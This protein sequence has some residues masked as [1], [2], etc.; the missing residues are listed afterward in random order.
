MRL[1]Q[2]IGRRLVKARQTLSVA[3]SCTGG[4]MGHTLTNVPGSSAFFR[5]GIIAYDNAAKTKLLK[6]PASLIKRY[7]AVS[8]EVAG[9]M[10]RNVRRILKTDIGISITGIAGPT[11]AGAGK[12]VGL[13]YVGISQGAKTEV[14]EFRFKG[15]RS[16]NKRQAV[17]AALR[18]L[19]AKLA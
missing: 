14:F 16:A 17:Q 4:L 13:T 3:E 10:A 15:N 9:Q 18:I 12:P 11:G 5:L 1:E 8:A 2:N 6:V 19:N 7:G